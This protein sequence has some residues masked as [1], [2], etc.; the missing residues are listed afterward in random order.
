MLRTVAAAELLELGQLREAEWNPMLHNPGGGVHALLSRDFAPL[1][2]RLASVAQRLA[3]VPAYLDA[4]RRRLAEMSAVH[5]ETA[6][7]QLDGTIGLVQGEVPAAAARA[8]QRVPGLEDAATTALAALRTHRQWL[9]GR[10][11]T[12]RRDPRIGPDLFRAKLALT[13]DTE[14]DPQALLAAAEA[15]LAE[16]SAQIVDQAGRIAGVARP[17]TGTVRD[18]LDRLA[19][20]APSDATVLGRCTDALAE[21]TAFVREH[22]LVTVLR[23]PDRGRGH[24]GDRP[25]RRRRVLRPERPAG[26]E[27]AADRVRGL[28]DPGRT[29]PARRSSRSTASTTTTCCTT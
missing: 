26:G 21:T 9:A 16:T 29:G 28:A 6:L 4:A 24:A 1:P 20:D 12:V 11:G 10:L 25:R 23:R 15:E 7:D 13:L 18:V 3:E 8:G 2:E 22:D 19:R 17:D 27:A 5:T 14:Y